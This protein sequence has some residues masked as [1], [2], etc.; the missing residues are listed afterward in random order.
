MVLVAPLNAP[1][2]PVTLPL[3]I[4]PVLK[5][6]SAAALKLWVAFCTAVNFSVVEALCAL[7]TAE[8]T[9]APRRAQNNSRASRNDRRA[10]L[11][12]SLPGGPLRR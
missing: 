4:T 7:A 8:P 5:M 10:N 2:P 3:V 6:P 12:D 9:N 1:V 11:H